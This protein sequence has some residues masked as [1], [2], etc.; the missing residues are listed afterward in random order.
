MDT[1]FLVSPS[2]QNNLGCLA[3]EETLACN[4]QRARVSQGRIEMEGRRDLRKGA[5]W[6]SDGLPDALTPVCVCVWVCVQRCA[7]E[8]EGGGG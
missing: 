8:G 2:L 3:C 1:D 6:R 7:S 5:G 4:V